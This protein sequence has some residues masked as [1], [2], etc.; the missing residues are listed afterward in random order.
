MG[1][2]GSWN[3]PGVADQTAGFAAQLSHL[4]TCSSDGVHERCHMLLSALG[5]D[6][7]PPTGLGAESVEP[8]IHSGSVG[9]FLQVL[10][11]GHATLRQTI[12]QV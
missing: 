9:Q 11:V 2:F 5:C 1:A 10:L 4:D 6:Q 3:D 12:Q 8:V 7:P